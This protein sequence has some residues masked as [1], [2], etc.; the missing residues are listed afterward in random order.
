[1]KTVH[2]CTTIFLLLTFFFMPSNIN[3][4]GLKTLQITNFKAE[5]RN[6]NA[7]ITWKTDKETIALWINYATV[8]QS[9]QERALTEYMTMLGKASQIILA[10]QKE[11]HLE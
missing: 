5:S 9:T 2:Q 3:A 10:L 11:Y 6:G 4:Q 8:V 7:G 1:M